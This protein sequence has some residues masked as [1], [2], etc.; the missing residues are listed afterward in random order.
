EL[1]ADV[2]AKD[3]QTG[4]ITT[5]DAITV[6]SLDIPAGA[7]TADEDVLV[8]SDLPATLTAEGAEVFAY[9]GSPMYQAGTALDDVTVAVALSE[10]AELPSV[11]NPGRWETQ[12]T[13]PVGTTPTGGA[14][15]GALGGALA[16]TGSGIPLAGLA[17]GAAA[18]SAAGVVAFAAARRRTLPLG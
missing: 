5:F 18:L 11:N 10:G 15:G 8:L 13:T 6:A 3:A 2:S 9:N 1:I 12:I 7:L 16:S 17:G 14:S 4:E